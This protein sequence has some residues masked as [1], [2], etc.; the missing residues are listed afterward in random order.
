MT[1]LF[2]DA[3]FLLR[4]LRMKKFNVKDSLNLLEKYLKIRSEHPEWF[5]NLDIK[6]P[7]ISDLVDRGFF[8]ALP[9]RDSAGRRV[10]FSKVG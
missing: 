9:E 8:F 7:R 2:L 10:F 1:S 5:S 3:N 4:F 6:D